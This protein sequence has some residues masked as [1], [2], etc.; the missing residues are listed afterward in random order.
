MTV[1]VDTGV[2]YAD[3]DPDV[4]RHE[5]DTP[6]DPPPMVQ[7]CGYFRGSESI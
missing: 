3:H 7:L 5:V 2:L 6:A 4:T 1:L